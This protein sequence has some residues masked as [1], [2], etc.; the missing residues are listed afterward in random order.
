MRPLKRG[1]ALYLTLAGLA[2]PF[3]KLSSA[4]RLDLLAPPQHLSSCDAE[5]LSWRA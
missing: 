4:C 2:T 3:V 1:A 5:E